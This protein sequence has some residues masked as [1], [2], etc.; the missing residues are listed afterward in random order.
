MTVLIRL[1]TQPLTQ[2]RAAGERGLCLTAHVCQGGRERAVCEIRSERYCTCG[3]VPDAYTQGPGV[4]GSSGWN[5]GGTRT[6][7][8]AKKIVRDSARTRTHAQTHKHTNAHPHKRTHAA[9]VFTSTICSRIA[10]TVDLSRRQM[11]QKFIFIIAKIKTVG[12]VI[13]TP[14]IPINL[15]VGR[16]E[17]LVKKRRSSVLWPP[18]TS[19]VCARSWRRRPRS[20][21]DTNRRASAWTLCWGRSARSIKPTSCVTMKTEVCC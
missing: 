16:S 4:P 1:D 5:S 18:E 3:Q 15:C 21:R 17:G 19:H 9:V 8:I 12:C 2:S 10:S 11:D 13:I 14:L 7:C 20:T 6:Q